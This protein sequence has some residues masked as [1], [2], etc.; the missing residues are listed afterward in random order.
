MRLRGG[1]RC[2]GSP[3]ISGGVRGRSSPIF[4]GVERARRWRDDG[5]RPAWPHNERD[6]ALPGAR[7]LWSRP[8]V[9]GGLEGVLDGPATAFHGHKGL[10][11]RTQRTP[12][13][14]EGHRPVGDVAPH[15]QA[16]RP[17]AWRT[18]ELAGVEVGEREV[19]PVVQPRALGAVSGR[20]AGPGFVRQL[21]CDRLRRSRHG[22]VLAP[23]AERVIGVGAEHVALPCTAQRHLDVAG[24]VDGVKSVGRL[25]IDIDAPIVTSRRTSQE[26]MPW[27]D[28]PSIEGRIETD[29]IRPVLLGESILPYRVWRPFESVVPVT[30]AGEMLNADMAMSRGYDGLGRWMRKAETIWK[31]MREAPTMTL[32]ERWNF[33]RELTAQFPQKA[34]QIVYAASGTNPA[35]CVLDREF[36]IEHKLYWF[37]PCSRLE[38]DYLAGLMNSETVRARVA[39]YQ[40]RGQFGARDFDKVAFNLPIPRFDEAVQL[41]CAIAAAAKRAEAAAAAVILP[42]GAK[43]QRARAMVRAALVEVGVAA[44]IDWLVARLLDGD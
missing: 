17:R 42:E 15:E 10:E 37:S 31:E 24:A 26:K 41:H 12:G 34:L 18:I 7:S 40:S 39:K 16:S 33:H 13:R 21:A 36:V 20:E 30:T 27:R 25:G 35:A 44:E 8:S 32:V 28:Q 4:L 29:F 38:A 3:A 5:S 22:Q 11:R 1:W 19:V 23:G 6:V 2:G 9:L 14:E 43:F